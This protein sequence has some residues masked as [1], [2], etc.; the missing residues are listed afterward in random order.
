MISQIVEKKINPYKV[1]Y[2]S[3]LTDGNLKVDFDNET[4]DFDQNRYFKNIYNTLKHTLKLSDEE[5]IALF[6]KCST[7]ISKVSAD[8]IPKIFECINSMYV[9]NEECNTKLFDEKEV[10][11]LLKINP[12]LFVLSRHKMWGALNYLENKAEIQIK[13]NLLPLHS[14]K[15]VNF[16]LN[17]FR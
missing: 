2:A 13:D 7:L 1:L 8:R 9:A 6:E 17:T 14:N 16:L 4:R 12:S 11:D 5:T 3:V 10:V 15:K